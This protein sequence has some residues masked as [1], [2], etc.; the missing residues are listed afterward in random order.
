MPVLVG[1][2]EHRRPRAVAG[3]VDQHVD[4]APALHRL[5]DQALEVVVRLVRAGHAQ[6]AQLLRQGR[7]LAGGGQDGHAKAIRGQPPRRIGTHA[8]AAGG[9]DRYFFN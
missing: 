1:Q 3:A 6:A 4:A 7:A 8:A 9:D 5:V 2:L